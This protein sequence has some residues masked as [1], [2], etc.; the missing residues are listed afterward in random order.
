[1]R[2]LKTLIVLLIIVAAGFWTAAWLSTPKTDDAAAF[3]VAPGDSTRVIIKHLKADGVIRS[4]LFFKVALK[5]SGLA[6]K[7]QPGTY[8]LRSAKDF[9][10]LIKLLTTGFVPQNEFVLLIR[11]GEN[12]ADIKK[13]LADAGFAGTDLYRVTGIPATDHR[14]LSSDSA[15]KPQDFSAAFPFLKDKPSYVSL[16]GFLFP[17]TYRFFRDATTEEVV[18]KLLSHFDEKLTPELRAEVATQ[19]KTVYDV[20]TLASV[21]E[22]EVRSSEDRRVVADIFWRRLEEGMPLQSDATVNYATGKSLP[23]VTLEDTANVSPYNT[24]K[25][26][27]LPMGPIDNPSIDAIE[28]VVHPTPNHY[29]YF[30]TDDTGN[31]H[32]ANTLDEHN[33][34][35]AKYL[36]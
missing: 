7:L 31:V 4:Q 22:R 14:T 20:V 6:A 19:G 32:Y 28:A 9:T 25:Y 33:R 34:N 24:Y 12:L 15:P 21:V 18:Q 30:L 1:M 5:S 8:D 13:S 3:T 2:F 10:S 16:E 27:G 36:K 26:R 23:S 29:V 35:K 17:D 11:E